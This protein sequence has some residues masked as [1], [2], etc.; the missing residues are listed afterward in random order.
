M[1]A[2]NE[3]RVLAALHV[4]ATPLTV[5]DLATETGTSP[6]AV[7]KSLAALSRSGLVEQTTQDPRW[8]LSLR[9]RRWVKTAI[10]R[11]AL[12]LPSP[13]PPIALCG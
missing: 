11:A 12:D 9:G 4:R 6:R 3:V 2:V 7:R 10:G 8:R 1:T 13:E 5:H